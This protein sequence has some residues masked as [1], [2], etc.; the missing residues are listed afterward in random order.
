MKDTSVHSEVERHHKKLAEL[1]SERKVVP[2]EKI[3]KIFNWNMW[4]VPTD[5][6]YV[7]GKCPQTSLFPEI[8]TEFLSFSPTMKYHFAANVT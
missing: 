1:L 6:D 7:S 8:Q 2:G 4:I 3:S 5:V